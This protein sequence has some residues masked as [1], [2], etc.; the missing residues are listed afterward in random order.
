MVLCSVSFIFRIDQRFTLISGCLIRI[1]KVFPHALSFEFGIELFNENIG[2][3]DTDLI[4][5]S[6]I[7]ICA[8]I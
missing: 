8:K 6:L 3:G 5:F 1:W 4:G 7:Q 2:F